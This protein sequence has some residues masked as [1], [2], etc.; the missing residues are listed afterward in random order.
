MIR[1]WLS[2]LFRY[3]VHIA[4]W[5]RII[6]YNIIIL[7]NEIKYCQHFCFCKQKHRKS[8]VFYLVFIVFNKLLFTYYY[9]FV[10]LY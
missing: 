9:T 2:V 6:I 4:R 10:L 1:I 7:I 3:F 5:I 8:L